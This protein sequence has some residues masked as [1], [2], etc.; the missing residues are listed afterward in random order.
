MLGR[1]PWVVKDFTAESWKWNIILPRK[2]LF[3]R[4]VSYFPLKPNCHGWRK[5]KTFQTCFGWYI[6]T[7]C[8]CIIYIH[9]TIISFILLA[10]PFLKGPDFP[11]N[12]SLL[13]RVKLP[14]PGRHLPSPIRSILK[15]SQW[16]R[17]WPFSGVCFPSEKTVECS[18]SSKY[19]KITK[20]ICI[21]D[22]ESFMFVVSF[23]FVF[24]EISI[25]W[26]TQIRIGAEHI[27][28]HALSYLMNS[29]L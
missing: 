19:P 3:W 23:F 13:C 25:V 21:S 8:F 11:L 20:W 12:T 27:M 1:I 26:C 18:Q 16:Q 22:F 7:C 29:N 4:E 24:C 15:C 10:P 2:Q 6:H 28:Q 17:Y 5:R 9:S 14:I